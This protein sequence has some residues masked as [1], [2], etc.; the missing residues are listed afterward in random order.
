MSCFRAAFSFTIGG[1]ETAELQAFFFDE[2]KR[3]RTSL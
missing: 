1:L 3:G 2:E